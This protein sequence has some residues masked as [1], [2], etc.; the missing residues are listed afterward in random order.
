VDAKDVAFT[1][2]KL[3]AANLRMSSWERCEFVRCELPDA[4]FSGAGLRASRLLASNLARVDFGKVRLDDVAF[5]GSNLDEIRGADAL[6]RAVVGSDQV[7]PL[8][9]AVF[10]ALRITV[11]DD[12]LGDQP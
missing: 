9:F 2:C 8:A 7:V 11:D 6:Q 4:D 1:D 5:H 3:D 10:A 12:Y